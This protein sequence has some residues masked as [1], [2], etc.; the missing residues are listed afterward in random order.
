MRA[1]LSCFP[2]FSRKLLSKSSPLVLSE[3]LGVLVNT[4]AAVGKD[5][6]EDCENLP[7]LIQM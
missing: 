7:L 5:L 1:I 2:L 3:I 6:I 4:L